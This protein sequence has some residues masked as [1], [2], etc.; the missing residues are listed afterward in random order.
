MIFS[1]K[2]E[3]SMIIILSQYIEQQNEPLLFEFDDGLLITAKIYT[4]YDS[5]NGKALDE[6]GYI[7]Y[8]ACAI[9]VINILNK[10]TGSRDIVKAGELFELGNKVI[11]LKIKS[12]EN[13]II[14]YRLD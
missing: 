1:S 14:W 13:D 12:N 5:D 3:E 7:E 10:G 8:H 9:E 2:N 4:F 11:P 6:D